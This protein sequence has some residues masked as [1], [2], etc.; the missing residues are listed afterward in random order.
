[1]IAF[2]IDYYVPQISKDA[3]QDLFDQW[4][5]DIR[6]NGGKRCGVMSSLTEYFDHEKQLLK[7]HDTE[8]EQSMKYL[9]SIWIPGPI[10]MVS[11]ILM[12]W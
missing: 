4:M 5:G 11:V 12:C 2:V 1:M 10:M 6:N 8:H 9:E 7:N 3:Y